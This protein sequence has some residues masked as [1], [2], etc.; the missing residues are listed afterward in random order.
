[1]KETV[2]KSSVNEINAMDR[3][4]FVRTLGGVF[5]H[6]PWVA[7]SAWALRPFASGQELHEAMMRTV[8]RS[9]PDAILELLRAHPDL[10]TRLAV[11]DYSA[12]EQQ[13][14][15]LGELTPEE[16]ETF[17][18][19]NESYVGKFGFPFILAVRGKNKEDILAAMQKRIDHS[20][21]AE[22]EQ[23]LREIERITGFR[24][25]DLI[26]GDGEATV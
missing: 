12:A 4:E 11:S 1:M 24:L 6:S 20:P 8:R 14:A 13:G 25:A 19:L 18:G 23:A 26:E 2:K 10:G 7:E 16:Y 3:D 21:E 22:R 9:G 15:G 17:R 5:E